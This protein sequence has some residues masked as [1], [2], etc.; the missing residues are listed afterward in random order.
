MKPVGNF[1]DESEPPATIKMPA[2]L[3]PV[4]K[5]IAGLESLVAQGRES[6]LPDHVQFTFT[7]N[8]VGGI[9]VEITGSTTQ[10]LEGIARMLTVK[11]HNPDKT[12]LFE[13]ASIGDKSPADWLDSERKRR[14]KSD[15]SKPRPGSSAHVR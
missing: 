15:K 13:S 6:G 5:Q 2:P 4:Q 1:S 11:L 8:D 3:D 12:S 7:P 10:E 9:D 14:D